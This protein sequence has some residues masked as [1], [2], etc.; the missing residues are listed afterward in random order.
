VERLLPCPFCGG[1]A[2][3]QEEHSH[4]WRVV[5][6][7]CG[8]Q[9]PFVSVREVDPR[10][11]L[12]AAWNTRA[13]SRERDTGVPEGFWLAP[14]KPTAEMMSAAASA[15]Y[16]KRRVVECGGPIGIAMTVDDRDFN[17]LDAFK[18]FWK[19]ARSAAPQPPTV[20]ALPPF[21]S[22]GLRGAKLVAERELG[23]ERQ[24]PTGLA[25]DV[26]IATRRCAELDAAKRSVTEPAPL[27]DLSTL[28]RERDQLKAD[29]ERAYEVDAVKTR[30]IVT[31][32]NEY[33]KVHRERDQAREALAETRD[34][35]EDLADRALED[36][37]AD[38]ERKFDPYDAPDDCESCITVTF[39]ELRKATKR[40]RSVLHPEP[41]PSAEVPA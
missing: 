41:A 34:L 1:E 33:S 11:S 30:E 15:H 25:K 24:P 27:P 3:Y 9:H 35:I 21:E 7:S 2:N 29:L 31:R 38:R 12:V 28:T 14:I 10:P 20:S 5:C 17:F 8:V 19:G 18:A 13:V 16:G 4:H 37:K 23:I 26:E 39:G 22:A 32:T 40:A 36:L 6:M